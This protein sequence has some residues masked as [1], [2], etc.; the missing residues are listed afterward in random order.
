[1]RGLMCPTCKTDEHLTGYEEDGL[2][3][4]VNCLKPVGYLCHGC[5][6]VYL[7]NRLGLHGDVYECKICG[8]IQWGFTEF[9]RNKK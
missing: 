2:Y 7:E 8:R 6:K 4:C 3:V 5:D 1:M 9:M